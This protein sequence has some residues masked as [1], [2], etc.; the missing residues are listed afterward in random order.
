M[1]LPEG[2][3]IRRASTDEIDTLVA[4][5][6]AMFVD[7]GYRDEAALDAMGRQMSSLA[8]YQDEPGRISGVACN[9]S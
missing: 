1:S 8:A 3:A 6:R 7:M 9:R 2:F 4:H 5:R